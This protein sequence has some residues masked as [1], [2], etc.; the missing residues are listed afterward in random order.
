MANNNKK[1]THEIILKID[2]VVEIR[3]AS[4]N[5]F[6]SI[7]TNTSVVPDKKRILKNFREH[8]HKKNH[9]EL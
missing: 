2:R 6:A 9:T 7:D 3:R 8:K 5:A 1:K 4:R